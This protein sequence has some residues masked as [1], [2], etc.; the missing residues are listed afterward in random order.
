M[1]INKMRISILT[2]IL[3]TTVVL[4]SGCAGTKDEQSA[5]ARNGAWNTQKLLDS[6]RKS[7]YS[8]MK[9]TNRR[10]A[11]D[12]AKEGVDYAERCLMHAPENAG[13]YYWRAVNTGLYY[14]IRIVGY[15][16]GIK[17]M[18]EDCKKVIAIN[19]DYD[20]AG[21][22]RMLGQIYTKLP[23]T[24]AR[25]DSVTRDL[26]LAEKYL[27]KATQLAPDYPEN[28]LALAEVLFEERK[29]A[30]AIAAL[31]SARDMAPHWQSDISYSAWHDEMRGLEKKIAKRK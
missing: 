15:Q 13:C 6:S 3:A 21:A 18:I 11:K 25:P 4:L 10:M 16:R 29:L 31:S 23:Q 5:L 12:L 27:R 7:A 30:E 8:S 28:Y 2:T 19:P 17:Q 26:P 22:Y 14:K 24:G 9:E 20:H 1:K